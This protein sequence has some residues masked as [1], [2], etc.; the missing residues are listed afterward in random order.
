M[1]D[2]KEYYL[3]TN[4]SH[5]ERTGERDE[6]GTEGEEYCERLKAQLLE[7]EEKF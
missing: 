2:S 6:H 3:R 1:E 5:P 4:E 7:A